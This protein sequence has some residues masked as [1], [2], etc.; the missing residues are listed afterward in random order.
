[1]GLEPTTPCLQ[2]RCS[3]QLSYVPETKPH[4]TGE[5]RTLDAVAKDLVEP[6]WLPLVILVGVWVY[7]WRTS[8]LGRWVKIIGTS[9]L[10]GLWLACTPLS[11]LLLERP[12]MVESTL[13]DGWSPRYIFVLSAGF[14]IADEPELDASGTETVR[15]VNRAVV[16]WRDY[17]N[18]TLVMT[19]AQPGMQGLQGHGLLGQSLRSPEQQGQLMQAQAQRL[20]VPATNIIIEAISLNTKGHAEQAR[21]SA[22]FAPDMALAIVTSD[23][24]LRRARSEFSRYFNNIRMIGSDP[25]ITDNSFS[26]ISLASLLPRTEA[27]AETTMYLRE[28]VALALSD[29]R[30]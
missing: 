16:L 5:I 13:E 26:D 2:S 1:M 30:S 24:H 29:L 3:S 20:G 21:D 11:A 17:P 10:A 14:D 22:L 18:A 23:F 8:R 12:L 9:A 6:L 19:G 4:S 25:V 27:V 28:Y 15:R 7:L